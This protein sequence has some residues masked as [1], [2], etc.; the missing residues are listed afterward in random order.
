MT[1]VFL[2]SCIVE[3]KESLEKLNGTSNPVVFYLFHKNMLF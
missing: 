3:E 1:D 2:I